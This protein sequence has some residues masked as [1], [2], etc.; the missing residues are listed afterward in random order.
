MG[1]GENIY[2]MD[3]CSI[4][5]AFLPFFKIKHLSFG[6]IYHSHFHVA[7]DRLYLSILATEGC[8]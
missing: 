7:S 3:I 5:I 1:N 8:M 6:G 4:F 2:V